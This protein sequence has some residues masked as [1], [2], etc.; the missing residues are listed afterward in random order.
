LRNQCKIVDTRSPE[1][2]VPR[3][4]GSTLEELI[5]D[6]LRWADATVIM[7][8]QIDLGKDRTHT[9]RSV[10]SFGDPASAGRSTRNKQMRRRRT[11]D[12]SRS[13]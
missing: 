7:P 10:F 13:D 6:D 5:Q 12:S 8:L 1:Y 9:K 2:Q 11:T 3:V 4:E